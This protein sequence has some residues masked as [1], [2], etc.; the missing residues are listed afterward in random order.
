MDVPVGDRQQESSYGSCPSTEHLP[1]QKIQGQHGQRASYGREHAHPRDVHAE[2]LHREGLQVREQARVPVP[3]G[4]K[5][6]KRSAFHNANGVHG[7]FTFV[8]VK[9]SGD[10]IEAIGSQSESQRHNH[11]HQAHFD[12]VRFQSVPVS[13][14]RC[15]VGPAGSD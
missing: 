3:A 9:T 14:Y 7:P 12:P 6:G 8:A 5:G 11:Y 13:A 2:D 1:D 10:E 4:A 15:T